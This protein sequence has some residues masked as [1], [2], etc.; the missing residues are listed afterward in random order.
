MLI[1]H[2]GSPKTGTTAL[3]QFLHSNADALRKAGV[4]YM[5]AARTHIAHNP[6]A[7][8]VPQGKAAELVAQIVKEYDANPDM[9]HVV[10]SE[11]MFRVVV[12]NGLKG[13]F[14]DHIARNTK[15]IC[16]LR[17]QDRYAEVL[18]KQLAKNALVPND[19]TSFLAGQIKKLAFT[20]FLDVYAEMFGTENIRIKPFD[21]KAF[22]DG[23]I[24]ADFAED[25]LGLSDLS[26]FDR[27]TREAN[28]SMS[29]ELSEMLGAISFDK[30][31]NVRQLIRVLS[32]YDDPL[33]FSKNDTFSLEN[34]VTLMNELA[35]DNEKLRATYAPHLPQLFDMSDLDSGVEDVELEPRNV[36]ARALAGSRALGRAILEVTKMQAQ[37][38][39]AKAVQGAALAQPKPAESEDDDDGMV[40]VSSDD[41]P[42]AWF[43]DIA[44]PK[45]ATGFYRKLNHHGAAFVDRGRKQLL[46][47]F[48]NLHNVG[49]PRIN[50]TLW[51][52]KF[53]ADQ[54]WSFLG[55]FAQA[56]VW[57]R[58]P[59]L[60]EMFEDLRENGFFASFDNVAFAGTSMGAFA[61]LSFSSCAPGSTVLAFS[62]QSTLD[63]TLVP[64]ETRFAKGRAADWSLAFSDAAKEI[65]TARDVQ[66]YYDPFFEPDRKQVERLQGENV[67]HFKCFGF[68]H[69]SAL[70]LNRM[71]HLKTVMKAG[72]EGSLAA[73]DFYPMIRDRRNIRLY[74]TEMQAHLEAKGMTERSE[75][76]KA[77][78]RKRQRQSGD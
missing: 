44:P 51:A 25:M 39:I 12:A 78:F 9:T 24:V 69:K 5:T 32:T 62:P 74:L 52:E 7:Q 54:G 43:V 72:I 33:L 36:R 34:R 60:I 31:A 56:P 3:Q 48:D 15:V 64:W 66:L 14:T 6:L 47:T 70:V 40:T 67:R 75:R 65:A 58:D 38:A 27:P 26:A 49:D 63:E 16:Y 46:V 68:G 55:V 8:A 18:Y 35:Q 10:S 11:I 29:V 45:P 61:A 19:R 71:G 22:K 37:A 57:Y 59:E 13:L 42:P 50:R 41:M 23:D 76:L 28:K 77:A 30:T 73:S 21:R 1:L 4:N 20:N 2:I 53:A 17:R